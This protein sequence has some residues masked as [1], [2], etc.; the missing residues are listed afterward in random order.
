MV[1]CQD[2]LHSLPSALLSVWPVEDV[3]RG[4]SDI[5]EIDGTIKHLSGELK[6]R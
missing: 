1:R 2:S 4:L 5:T 6:M 3:L